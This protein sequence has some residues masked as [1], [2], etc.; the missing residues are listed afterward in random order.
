MGSLVAGW[1]WSLCPPVSAHAELP[2]PLFPDKGNDKEPPPMLCTAGFV[3]VRMWKRQE[4]EK[5]SSLPSGRVGRGTGEQ[6]AHPG[7][8]QAGK[9]GATPVKASRESGEQR[10][11][12]PHQLGV[13]GGPAVPGGGSGRRLLVDE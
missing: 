6:Q 13:R 7:G 3:G 12:S 4:R 2:T 9:A 11:S 8:S 1:L 10:P 5:P